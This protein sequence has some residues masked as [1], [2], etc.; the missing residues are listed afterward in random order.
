LHP[1]LRS[2]SPV[3]SAPQGATIRNPR[4]LDPDGRVVNV[5]RPAQLYPYAYEV[6]F[7][8][9]AFDVR[10]GM[11]LRLVTGFELGGQASP[12]PRRGIEHIEAGPHP[13]GRL[14]FQTLLRT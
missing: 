14:P 5:L 4:F 1:N 6:E 9:D 13:P 12:P 7:L 8:E 10:F 3:E 11:M 2:E